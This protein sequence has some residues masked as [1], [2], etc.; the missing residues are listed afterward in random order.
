[1]KI[2]ELEQNHSNRYEDINGKIW[3]FDARG[4]LVSEY[5]DDDITDTHS[6]GEMQTMDFEL[7]NG[8]NW[9]TVAV[10]TP[11][12]V[13]DMKCDEW[14]KRHF[15]RFHDGKVYVFPLGSTSWTSHVQY[16]LSYNY[17]KLP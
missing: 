13:R 8:I 15:A 7:C 6:W 9:K 2:W 10:D 17:A 12:Y 14:N 16:A 4:I 3:R 11:I 5:T 1:M